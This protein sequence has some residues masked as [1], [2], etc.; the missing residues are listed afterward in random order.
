M[1]EGTGAHVPLVVFEVFINEEVLILV[2]NF[3]VDVTGIYFFS[4]ELVALADSL[5]EPGNLGLGPYVELF[6]I[7]LLCGMEV[8]VL[9]HV[10]GVSLLGKSFFI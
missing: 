8:V 1:L 9:T 7:G 10:H 3:Q 4:L 2:L 6:L 5:L